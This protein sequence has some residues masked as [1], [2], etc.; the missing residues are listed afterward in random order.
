MNE[1]SS[2]A[3]WHVL[4]TEPKSEERVAAALTR[5]GIASYLPKIKQERVLRHTRKYKRPKTRTIEA[6]MFPRYV[7]AAAVAADFA[8]VDG[9]T[10]VLKQDGSWARLPDARIE[11]LR[12]AVDMGL[13]DS[14]RD[15][16]A[17]FRPGEDVRIEDG[18]LAGLPA[19]VKKA[20][21]GQGAEVLIDL[22]GRSTLVRVELDMLRAA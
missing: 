19:K 13:F 2:P 4:F 21:S 1:M 9:V 12:V 14:T 10:G 17:I 3:E 8:A 5:L 11:E 20:L 6:V 15:R 7:F 16:R 18:P 22:L